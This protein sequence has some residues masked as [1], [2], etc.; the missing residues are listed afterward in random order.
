MQEIPLPELASTTFVISI[1][2]LPPRTH[3]I[4]KALESL[5]T[6]RPGMA[7]FLNV[8]DSPMARPRLSPTILAGL[9]KAEL[10]L[11]TIVHLTVRDRNRVALESEILG[12]KAL[13][14]HH[15]LAVSG[16]PIIYCDREDARE[17]GDMHVTDLIALCRNLGQVTGVVFDVN[18]RARERELRKMESKLRAGAQFVITQPIYDESHASE[19]GLQLRD[20]GIPALMGVLPLYSA[21]HTRFLHENV[22]GINIPASVR[23]AMVSAPDAVGEGVRIAQALLPIARQH[24]QGA[25]L[26]PPFGHYELAARILSAPT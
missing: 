20:F 19:V 14:V 17:V 24:F 9:L 5:S 21:R 8:A 22:P 10:G 2:V 15:N 4:H 12:A 11:D 7:H 6:L 13:G 25:C 3:S 18:P 26:M 16:D 23:D 1:E